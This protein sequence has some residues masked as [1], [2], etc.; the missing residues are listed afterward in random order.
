MASLHADLRRVL[1]DRRSPEATSIYRTL[2]AF[3]ERRIATLAR[4]RCRGLLAEADR[5]EVLGEVLFQLTEGALGRFRGETM[6]ELLA[7]VRTMCDRTAVRRAQRRLRERQTVEDLAAEG[8]EVWRPSC[9]PRP[10]E[11]VEIEALSPL[12][13]ADRVYLEA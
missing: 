7:F 9:L 12:D 5:E 8:T 11:G 3:A 13:E 4:G 6:A 2:L 10:D 1:A